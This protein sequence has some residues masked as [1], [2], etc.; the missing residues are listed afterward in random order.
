[1][2]STLRSII[3]LSLIEIIPMFV[4]MFSKSSPADLLYVGKCKMTDSEL[5][6][7]TVK[8]DALTL[9]DTF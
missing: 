3:E 2:F 9:V 8:I 1:M 7:E 4:E 6:D 5:S